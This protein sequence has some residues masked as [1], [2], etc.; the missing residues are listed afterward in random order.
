MMTKTRKLLV[1]TWADAEWAIDFYQ[2]HGFRLMPDKDRLLSTYWSIS[3]RQIETSV[4]LGIT[5]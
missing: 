3:Q 5:M 4:V 2:K 1:G